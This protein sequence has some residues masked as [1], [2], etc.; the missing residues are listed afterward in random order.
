[1]C[2]WPVIWVHVMAL[3]VCLPGFCWSWWQQEDGYFHQQLDRIQSLL[4]RILLHSGAELQHDAADKSGANL[5]VHEGLFEDSN[6]DGI[7]ASDDAALAASPLRAP[8]IPG[9]PSF[10]ESCHRLAHVPGHG[11]TG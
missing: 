10:S 3:P 5:G 9:D 6:L 8:G 11:I 7:S 1:M 2:A 4:E